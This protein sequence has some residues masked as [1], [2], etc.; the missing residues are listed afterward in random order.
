MTNTAARPG[1]QGRALDNPA[2]MFTAFDPAGAEV[3]CTFADQPAWANDGFCQYCGRTDHEPIAAPATSAPMFVPDVEP[4][5][6]AMQMTLDIAG[7]PL[8]L[9]DA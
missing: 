7:V 5:D 8:T 1:R 6:S 9:A 2:Q 3:F 4:G